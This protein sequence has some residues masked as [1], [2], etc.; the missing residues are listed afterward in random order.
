MSNITL[1]IVLI[2]VLI[3]LNG[4]LAMA[5]IA[6]VSARKAR[7]QQWAETGKKNARLALEISRSPEEFLSTVQVGITLVGVLAGAFGGATIAEELS[8]IFSEVPNLAP[9]AESLAL[10]LVV[11]A[12]TYLSLVLGELLP[13]RIALNNAE[14]IA[15][16]VAA[17]MKVF[18]KAASPI[19]WL[20]SKST[21]A[22]LWLL[23]MEQKGEAPVSED[24]IRIL[25]RQG[26]DAG[27]I[28]RDEQEI[29]D[30]VFRFGDKPVN[31]IMT[32]RTSLEVL[33]TTDSIGEVC[34][35][36][37][38]T[39]HSVFPLCENTIDN[40]VGIIRPPDIL[41]RVLT[42]EPV[43][44]KA[45]ARQP[46]FLPESVQSLRL[47]EEFKKTGNDTALILDEYGGLQGLITPTD[48][49]NAIVGE[50]STAEEPRAIRRPDG[51]WLIDG[52]LPL[53]E[54]K[55][56]LKISSLPDEESRA[57][58]NAGGFVMVLLERIPSE[59]ETVEWNNFRFEIV[60]MDGRRV[61]KILATRK[62]DESSE[63]DSR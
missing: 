32:P 4:V 7:L 2:I 19:V 33:Y 40:V 47:L 24:E 20:L 42:K 54:L 35:K 5:E 39:G 30:R 58:T 31:N 56:A 55:A 61:D 11:I 6:M 28:Q 17:P 44:L 37:A 8:A 1:E 15:S 10:G 3:L 62:P 60:D 18:S 57:Y 38:D 13:K 34:R 53:E 49:L 9:Y 26:T 46:L 36:I 16:I 43:D 27:T 63:S 22:L 52:T 21:R 45:L 41:E 14:R 50:L 29:L 25:I 23:R 51:S 12:I 59:G 48:I